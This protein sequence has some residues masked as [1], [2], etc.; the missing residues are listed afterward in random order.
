MTAKVPEGFAV[1]PKGPRGDAT[2]LCGPKGELILYLR[3][4]GTW[5]WEIV[6]FGRKRHYRVD[7]TCAHSAAMLAAARP[8]IRRRTLVVGWGGKNYG[9]LANRSDEGASASASAKVGHAE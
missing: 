3:R 6:C 4:P 2:L 5:R 1:K 8:F 7:G 9:D